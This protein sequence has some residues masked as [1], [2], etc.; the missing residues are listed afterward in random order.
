[1]D[2]RKWI[3]DAASRG[4]H[5]MASGFGVASSIVERAIRTDESQYDPMLELHGVLQSEMNDEER[6]MLRLASAAVLDVFDAAMHSKRDAC[7]QG[8]GPEDIRFLEVLKSV[9]YP[10]L[11]MR[12]FDS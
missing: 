5:A 9:A 7:I 1:M 6:R 8:L 11:A 3:H 4:Y 10:N 12:C 2:V